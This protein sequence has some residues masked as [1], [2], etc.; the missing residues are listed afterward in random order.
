MNKSYRLINEKYLKVLRHMPCVYCGQKE[1]GDIYY[2]KNGTNFKANQ[3]P[4]S[5][6]AVPLC[7]FCKSHGD[8]AVQKRF[9]QDF[10]DECLRS[11]PADF[12]F[13]LHQIYKEDGDMRDF[14]KKS[15]KENVMRRLIMRYYRKSDIESQNGLYFER[16]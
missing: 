16:K 8:Y 9:E 14:I 10:F 1:A 4:S 11:S 2:V 12:A 6:S 5:N 15:A 7:F 3:K 13:R